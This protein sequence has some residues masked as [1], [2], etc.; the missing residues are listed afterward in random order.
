M[1]YC[2]APFAGHV[3]ASE[4]TR[5]RSLAGSCQLQGVGAYCLVGFVKLCPDRA[6]VSSQLQKRRVRLLAVKRLEPI[7]VRF[8]IVNFL[9]QP[10]FPALQ[11]RQPSRMMIGV[12]SFDPLILV[13]KS[14]TMFRRG[15]DV[16]SDA[17][18]PERFPAA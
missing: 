4:K 2:D 7:Q 1:E 12:H 11:G 10:N 5:F 6:D 16:I 9:A 15:Q 13:M 14:S 8:R 17:A 3:E 18:A